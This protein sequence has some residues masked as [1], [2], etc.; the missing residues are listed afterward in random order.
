M[1][2]ARCQDAIQT[3]DYRLTGI[4]EPCGCRFSGD[5]TGAGALASKGDAITGIKRADTASVENYSMSSDSLH[6]GKELFHAQRESP[7]SRLRPSHDCA[8]S[9]ETEGGPAPDPR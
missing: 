1:A 5:E 6:D 7:D 8:S 2:G 4:P 3:I 9:A